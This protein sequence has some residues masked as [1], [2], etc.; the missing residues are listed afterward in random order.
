MAKITTSLYGELAILPHPAEAPIK[1]TLEFLTDVMQ[2]YNGTEQ[3]L[4]L[5]TKARQTFSYKIPLQAWHLAS[6]FNTTYAAIR[7][8]WAVP[9]W[10]EGQ[11][12]GNIASGAISI[13]CN[14]TFY[15]IRANSLAMIYG[16]YDNW[17]IVQIGTVGPS[18][19]NLASGVSEVDSAWLIPIRLGRIPGDIRKPTNGSVGSVEVD[20]EIEDALTFT[21]EAPSQYLSK[22]IY[23]DVPLLSDSMADNSVSKRLDLVD[24]SLGPKAYRSPWLNSQYGRPYFVSLEERSDI[25][26]FKKFVYRRAGKFREFYMPSHEVNLRIRNESTITNTLLVDSDSFLDYAS[27]RTKIAVQKIDGSWLLRTISNP[28]Q[29]IGNRLQFTLSSSLNLN[30]SEIVRVSYLGEYR[31]EADRIEFS[32]ETGGRLECDFRILELSA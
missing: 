4:P 11:F 10:S 21:P 17:Q 12:I 2:A 6:S 13:V 30:P 15:D 1:E 18:V 23:Y 20:F 26:E 24:Y 7:D 3:R 22:D 28:V 25:Y 5:R 14:T 27:S 8:R 16:G 19:A 31:M 9:I 32:W 29:I